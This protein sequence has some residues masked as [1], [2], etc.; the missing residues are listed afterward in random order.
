METTNKQ[1]STELGQHSYRTSSMH[2]SMLQPELCNHKIYSNKVPPKE[3]DSERKKKK[4][5]V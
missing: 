2:N 4:R 3:I 1:R 5:D